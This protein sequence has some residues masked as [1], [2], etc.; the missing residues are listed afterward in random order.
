MSFGERLR[1]LDD[2]LRCGDLAMVDRFSP[3]ELWLVLTR[4]GECDDEL[5]HY[6]TLCQEAGATLL[7]PGFVGK[8][9]NDDFLATAFKTIFPSETF[10]RGEM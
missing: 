5:M 1:Y 7:H 8:E 6:V 3:E 10:E 4:V 2:M 9:D